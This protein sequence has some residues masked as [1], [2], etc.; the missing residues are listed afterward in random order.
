M[1]IPV[2]FMG[3][4]IGKI[5]FQFGVTV[6][7]AV[8]VSLFVSFTLD[9]ML[10]SVWA[11]PDVENTGAHAEAHVGIRSHSR[12]PAF[13]DWF[14][15]VADRY[16]RLARLGA[17]HRAPSWRSRGVDRRR[18]RSALPAC[19]AS[20][21]C[22]T[23]NRGEFNVGFRATPGSRSSTRR[24]KG[25]RSRYL[26]REPEV[27]FTYLDVGGGFRG[28]PN[29]GSVYV[30]LKPQERARTQFEVQNE[31]RH[32]AA[33]RCPASARRSPGSAR[34]SAASDSRSR[35]TCRAGAS[36][37]KL[38][39]GAG[40]RAD[41]RSARRRRAELERRRARSRSST[42][43]SI[44]AGVGGRPRHR[45][46]ATT[47]QPLFAGQRATRWEDPQGYSH[48]VVVVYP[49]SLRVL[50]RRRREHPVASTNIDPRTATADGA[51]LAGRGRARRRRPAADRA[52]PA[53]AR[54]RSRRRAPGLPDGRR[55]RRGEAA[56][57]SIGLP[58]GY[59]TVFG[60]DVQNL[61]ETKG[62][63]LEAML[64][65]VVFIYLI[66]ASLFGSFLQ[67]LAIMLA[68]PLQ[69]HRRR[70]RAADHEGNAQRHDDDRHHHAD[71]ARHEE[72]HP[73]RRLRQPA[74][75]ARAAA[76]RRC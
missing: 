2:A 10:S 50:G 54:S 14:E 72:R 49:D 11:D 52:A 34:S 73:A 63:V 56:I 42:C 31:L 55:R 75:R 7:F 68:L 15:R 12:R 64:L 53:S 26:R 62:Y 21:G 76:A 29:N 13:N 45:Q 28:T 40:A 70:A 5:F 18:A 61:E 59:R 23:S 27:E 25:A 33:N 69:L 32:R 71:G 36:R 6:A 24:P 16:P 1:F 74:A 8:L 47:L 65:A 46:I 35:S 3:G 38:A 67:P 19:S 57:D 41:A 22:R 9:P 39:R 4:M 48:D 66:L 30:R 20:P 51:A 44:A 58:P 43:A 17:A 60:G 37:L